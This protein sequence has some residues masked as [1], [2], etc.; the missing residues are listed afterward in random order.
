MFLM[1][2]DA[3]FMD[4]LERSLYNNVLSG[5]GLSGDLFFYPNPLESHGQH[6]RS[7]WFGCA[8]CPSNIS[9]FIPSMPNYMYAQKNSNIYVNLYAASQTTLR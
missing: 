7:E 3:K 4:V 5:V 9:R 1:T 6:Q 8:C 2:G